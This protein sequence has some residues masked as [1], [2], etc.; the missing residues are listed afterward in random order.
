MRAVL[1]LVILGALCLGAAQWQGRLTRSAQEQREARAG[2]PL[3]GAQHVP[4]EEGWAV[5]VLGAE[6]RAPRLADLARSGATASAGTPSPPPPPVAA[7]TQEAPNPIPVQPPAPAPTLAPLRTHRVQRGETLGEIC[8]EAY[9]TQKGGLPLALARF[10]GL[11][12]PG[13]IREGQDLLIPDRARLEL[14]R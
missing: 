14:P 7:A 5:L 13:Q 2:I 8:V 6:S 12:D 9:G 4:G 3:P 10:N 1:G 11:D